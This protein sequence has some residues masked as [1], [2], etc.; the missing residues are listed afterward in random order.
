MWETR[1]GFP[2]PSASTAATAATPSPTS[3]LVR[4]CCGTATRG[5]RLERRDRRKLGEDPGRR[6]ARRSSPRCAGGTRTCAATAEEVDAAGAVLG[7]RG[8]VLRGGRGTAGVRGLPARRP[9]TSRRHPVERARPG[10]PISDGLRGP[11]RPRPV[12]ITPVG[13]PAPESPMRRE[14]AVVCDAPGLP[15]AL[16]AWELPGQSAVPD[17]RRIFEAVWTVDPWRVRDAARVCVQVAQEARRR[18]GDAAALRARRHRRRRRRPRSVPPLFN[19]VVAYVDRFGSAGPVT[20]W[21]RAGGPRGSRRPTGRRPR[22]ARANSASVAR[23]GVRA[24]GADAGADLVDQVLDARAGRVEVHPRRRDALL[25]EPLAGPV[26]R[27]LRR[28]A[29]GHGAGRGHP[30][31]TPCRRGR[32]RP[33]SRSP[34]DSWVPANH[35]PIITDEAPAASASATSRGC[36]T[37]PSAQTCLPS[38]R[39]RPRRTRARRENCGRPTP[40]IIRVVH[41]APG[42]T[43]TLTMSAPASISARVPSA[44]TTLPA[45]TG[46]RRVQGADRAAAPRASGPGGRGRCRRRGSRRRPRAARA[47]LAATSPLTPIAAAIRSPPAASTAGG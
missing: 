10:R 37:P 29:V 32:R 30:E 4:R 27:R 35:E 13:A 8:R 16:T 44:E 3:R 11:P 45:T 18:R 38:S 2:Y 31:A 20:S 17:R 25:V 1:H 47:A 34:G 43:P 33:A 36:R 19:R 23:A 40:V 9:T 15:G 6:S 12:R 5:L 26:E 46:H 22:R 21:W 39:A 14:W 42:P 24:G 41:I 7:D 28:R